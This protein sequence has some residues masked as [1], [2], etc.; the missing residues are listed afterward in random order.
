MLLWGFW[1]CVTLDPSC[2]QITGPCG[3]K[4]LC[5][6]W[7][8]KWCFTLAEPLYFACLLRTW[9]MRLWILEEWSVSQYLCVVFY[10][11]IKQE[12]GQKI[13]NLWIIA[14]FLWTNVRVRN[15]AKWFTKANIVMGRNCHDW[16]CPGKPP[17]CWCNLCV[18]WGYTLWSASCPRSDWFT[19]WESW[20]EAGEG[21]QG[22]HE[23]ENDWVKR[24]R[25]MCQ[26]GWQVMVMIHC[27]PLRTNLAKTGW[28]R[29]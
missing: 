20:W 23:D 22:P 17:P 25:K 11:V 9:K 5:G 10:Q 26:T 14:D 28:I 7:G 2:W 8:L 16:L 27:N 1:M 6:R 13:L 24:R 19:G 4:M 18:S 12:K 21:S 3:F 29:S 15:S